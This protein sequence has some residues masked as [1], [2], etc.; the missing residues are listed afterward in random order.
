MRQAVKIKWFRECSTVEQAKALH[1]KLALQHH[2]DKGGS[3]CVMQEINAKWDYVKAHPNVLQ[4]SGYSSRRTK[5]TQSRR[6]TY[7]NSCEWEYS[8]IQPGRYVVEITDIRDNEEKKYLGLVFDIAEG[9][10]KKYYADKSWFKHCIYLKYDKDWQ[11]RYTR[12]IIN[13]IS[14]S[15]NDFDGW[16]AFTEGLAYK[17]IGKKL[18]V[19]L[20]QGFI[21]EIG[22]INPGDVFAL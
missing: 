8:I 19:K 12:K 18:G 16:T 3:I 6:E 7:T 4:G 1:R 10:Y 17:F 21:N 9:P 20:S 2:P 11:V 5:R 22:F 15:N 14:R 13:V